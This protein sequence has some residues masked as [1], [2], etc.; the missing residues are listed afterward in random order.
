MNTNKSGWKQ[1]TVFSLINN[2]P[3]R[4]VKIGLLIKFNKITTTVFAFS[5]VYGFPAVMFWS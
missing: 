4:E 1:G 5:L 2:L 3:R